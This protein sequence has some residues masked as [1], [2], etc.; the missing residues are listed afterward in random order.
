M[1]SEHSKVPDIPILSQEGTPKD[2]AAEEKYQQLLDAAKQ[3]A[4]RI[5]EKMG[6]SGE[7]H[8]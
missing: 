4:K 1:I 3:R 7:D 8:W 5:L 2:C 6:I